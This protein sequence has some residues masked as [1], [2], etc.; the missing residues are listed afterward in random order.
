MTTFFSRSETNNNYNGSPKSG[1]STSPVT[2]EESLSYDYPDSNL[3][4]DSFQDNQKPNP[5]SLPKFN[6]MNKFNLAPLKIE[7]KADPYETMDIIELIDLYF[8]NDSNININ[9]STIEEFATQ[10]YQILQ[11]EKCLNLQNNKPESIDISEYDQWIIEQFKTSSPIFKKKTKQPGDPDYQE[12]FFN[13]GKNNNEYI[14][15]ESL[16]FNYKM[17]TTYF[18]NTGKKDFFYKVYQIGREEKFAYISVLREIVLHQY[19]L[20]LKKEKC[21]SDIYIPKILNVIQ[22][23]EKNSDNIYLIIK[24]EYIDIIPQI[25]KIGDQEIHTLYNKYFKQIH[26]LFTCFEKNHLFHN[27]THSDNL[28]FINKDNETQLAL[29]DFGKSTILKQMNQSSTGFRRNQPSSVDEFKQWLNHYRT[30]LQNY[31]VYEKN[32]NVYGG[33]KRKTN[34]KQ[35]TKKTSKKSK[36]TKTSKKQKSK[37]P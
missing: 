33:R 36:K 32:Y 30:N 22:Y 10:C 1:R 18:S 27:D 5:V 37:K 12:L 8:H 28:C 13:F 34:K 7:V 3:S 4:Q 6:M 11:S 31:G 20:Y 19:A 14:K 21:I 29:I 2:T 23:S 25:N 9:D 35:K 17:L 15:S 26:H 24:S 16:K